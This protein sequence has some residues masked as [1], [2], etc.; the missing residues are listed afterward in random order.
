VAALHKKGYEGQ[1]LH[2][3]RCTH[4]V[5]F[6]QEFAFQWVTLRY[7]VPGNGTY[8]TAAAT[9]RGMAGRLTALLVPSPAAEVLC[10]AA[11]LEAG[12][13]LA[14][15]LTALS[16]SFCVSDTEQL[17]AATRAV[18]AV[19][20]GLQRLN[21]ELGACSIGD[22]GA[23]QVKA[24]DAAFQHLMRSLPCCQSLRLGTCGAVSHQAMGRELLLRGPDLVSLTLRIYK[25]DE[26]VRADRQCLLHLLDVSRQSV[27]IAGLCCTTFALWCLNFG[28]ANNY[29]EPRFHVCSSGT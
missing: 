20:S 12:P 26:Q 14:G 5:T 28:T 10:T 17:R 18:L 15:A 27:L 23:A 24:A 6:A 13:Q 22:Y 25:F 19:S 1:T 7:T 9:L 11:L 29:I 3:P 21:L 8:Q 4:H 2:E 16:F